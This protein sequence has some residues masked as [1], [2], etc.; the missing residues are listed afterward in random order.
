MSQ[1]KLFTPIKSRK[2]TLSS[3]ESAKISLSFSA[4]LERKSLLMAKNTNDAFVNQNLNSKPTSVSTT[5]KNKK[6]T[7]A[8]NNH[9]YDALCTES[10][11]FS[12]DSYIYEEARRLSGRYEANQVTC[13]LD[14]KKWTP[15]SSKKAVKNSQKLK[16]DIGK[17]KKRFDLSETFA[18]LGTES[19]SC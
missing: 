11:S 6:M 19:S 13:S 1:P 2:T 10:K 3:R 9:N 4:S 5:K 8:K 7:K 14:P 16:T 12:E 15:Y 18:K 17:T